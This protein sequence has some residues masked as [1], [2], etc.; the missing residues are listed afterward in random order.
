MSYE[1]S[2]NSAPAYFFSDLNAAAQILDAVLPAPI[3]VNIEVGYGEIFENGADVALP[4]GFSEGGPAWGQYLSYSSVRSLLVSNATAPYAIAAAN[5]LP[6]NNPTNQSGVLLSNTQEK[7]FGML[8]S[9]DTATD[10]YVGFG[11]GWSSY[12]GVALHEITHAM[13]RAGNSSNTADTILNLYKFSSPGVLDFTT[14]A[15]YFSIDG[16]NTNLQNF[17]STGV[18]PWDWSAGLP[19]PFSLDG[20]NFSTLSSADIIVLNALGL[21]DLPP[22]PPAV[23]VVSDSAAIRGQT[24]PLSSLVTISDPAH[25]G[26][27]KLELWDANGSASGGQ[28]VVNGVA[29]SGG[30]EIDVAPGDVANTVFHVGTGTGSDTLWARLLENDGTLTPWQQFSVSLQPPTLTVHNVLVAT[31]AQVIPLSTLV[32]VSD[33]NGLSYQKPSCG[34]RMAQW[35]AVSSWSTAW[36]KRAAM[37]SM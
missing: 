8:P 24:L 6:I 17:D 20:S 35:Q 3:T 5:S 19:D 1:A 34:T 30:H 9:N 11:V 13:G 26:Y 36:R 21:T 33:P 37:K 7:L 32:T 10:G 14:A 2:A 31:R 15:G 22:P 27:Q 29:Q 4:S 12:L 28:F 18:D 16:G 25:K 23:S